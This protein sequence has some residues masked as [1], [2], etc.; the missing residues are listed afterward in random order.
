METSSLAGRSY[1]PTLINQ[2]R[3]YYSYKRLTRQ[4]AIILVG[5]P[6]GSPLC[7]PT[8][9]QSRPRGESQSANLRQRLCR[10][11][12]EVGVDVAE[13]EKDSK[14]AEVPE[15]ETGS[16]K[17]RGFTRMKLSRR[18]WGRNIFPGRTA[19]RKNKSNVLLSPDKRN[20]E[21]SLSVWPEK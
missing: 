1:T 10:K 16:K 5:V 11:R 3:P 8:A 19:G 13:L 6:G 4:G 15:G 17:S 9:G 21:I 2:A 7:K 20:T 18:S 12:V 14:G